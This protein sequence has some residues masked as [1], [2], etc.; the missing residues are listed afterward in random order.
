MIGVV[1]GEAE[2][3]VVRELFELFKTPWEF[4][5]PGVAYE[6]IVC[7]SA[8][9]VG[10]DARLIVAY[11]SKKRATDSDF[12]IEPS[13]IYRGRIVRYRAKCIPLYGDCLT[14]A[15]PGE[16]LIETEDGEVIALQLLAK[17]GAVVR[18]GF[19][20]RGN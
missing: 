3:A 7:S 16:P 11:G 6:V 9:P 10:S 17:S 18:V 19:D 13:G 15:G 1:A 2:R 20:L 14:L 12:G 4:C 8:E 5:R